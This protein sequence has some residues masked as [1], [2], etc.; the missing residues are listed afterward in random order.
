MER[1][2]FSWTDWEEV[3]MLTLRFTEIVLKKQIGVYPEGTKLPYAVVDFD[4]SELTLGL[5]EDGSREESFNLCLTV[6]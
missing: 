4:D 3:G 2:L 6:V 5:N 1:Q